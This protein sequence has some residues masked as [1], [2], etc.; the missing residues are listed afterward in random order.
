MEDFK[1]FETNFSEFVKR[2]ELN[3]LAKEMECFSKDLD[4]SCSKDELMTR[5]AVFS[6]DVGAKLEARPTIEYVRKVLSAYDLK[7]DGIDQAL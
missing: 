4:R 6:T 3:I 2:E 7:M 5:L 1:S